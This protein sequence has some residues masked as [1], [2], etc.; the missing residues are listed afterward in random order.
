MPSRPAASD[1]AIAMYGLI[2][3]PVS[4]SSTRLDFPS[5][6]IARTAVVRLSIPQVAFTGAQAPGT[7]RLY[8]FTVGQKHAI[9]SGRCATRP[10]MYCCISGTHA[11]PIRRCEQIVVAEFVPELWWRCPL[12]PGSSAF[13]FAM[14]VGIR[15]C[16]PAI[17]LTAVLNSA[18]RSAARSPS[19]AA[20]AAS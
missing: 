20:I 12:E 8:E 7:V 17:S 6:G 14:N 19:S 5:E 13:H 15:P 4:R 2:S 10:A 9:S 3:A 16:R 11:V 18:A 1:A